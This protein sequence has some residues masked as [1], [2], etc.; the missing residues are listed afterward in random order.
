MTR[1][2]LD[3]NVIT[4]ILKNEAPVLQHL[5][6]AIGRGDE[7]TLNAMSFFEVRRGLSLPKFANKY[8]RFQALVQEHDVLELDL[9]A[10][11]EAAI[12]Y[13]HLQ[14]TGTPLEDADLLIAATALRHDAVL[15]TR[16]TKHFAR[17]P[18]LR[19]EDWSST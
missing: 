9:P 17:I 18:N 5:R 13:Q 14:T 15:V 1:Y 12:L 7:I 3:T 2:T 8:A 19:L 16:N 4:A 10:M 6:A 11:E